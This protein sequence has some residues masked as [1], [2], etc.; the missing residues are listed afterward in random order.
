[1]EHVPI[2]IWL[3][4][5]KFT[6][7]DTFQTIINV[8][9]SIDYHFGE[10]LLA[11]ICRDIVKFNHKILLMNKFLQAPKLFTSKKSYMKFKSEYCR[12]IYKPIEATLWCKYNFSILKDA[13]FYK[14]H[15]ENNLDSLLNNEYHQIFGHLTSFHSGL[16]HLKNNET[17]LPF[18]EN[19]IP[20]RDIIRLTLAENIS[21][22][23]HSR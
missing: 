23:F 8:L 7:N 6:D 16:E 13:Y 20:I 15:I 3:T 11:L 9:Y 14:K 22:C 12:D 1:M 2:E 4:V 10:R 17:I 5:F 21:L 19:K 18:Y